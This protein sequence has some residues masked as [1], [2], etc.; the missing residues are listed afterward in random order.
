MNKRRA[1]LIPTF[2]PHF[3]KCIKFLDSC[4]VFEIG[5]CVPKFFVTSNK[6]EETE[7][8]LLVKDYNSVTVLNI[9]DVLARLN[10]SKVTISTFNI[11]SGISKFSYQSV[12]KIYGGFFLCKLTNVD[13]ILI[14]DSESILFKPTDFNDLF[15]D[16]FS[17]PKVYCSK[18]SDPILQQVNDESASLLGNQALSSFIRER[19]NFEAQTWFLEKDILID[20]FNYCEKVNQEPLI[21]SVARKTYV[22]EIIAYQWFIYL[23]P[24]KYGNYKFIKIEDL[25]FTY[26]NT[27]QA[28]LFLKAFAGARFGII[29]QFLY[30]VNKDNLPGIIQMIN[31]EKLHFVRIEK[32]FQCFSQKDIETGTLVLKQDCLKVIVCSEDGVQILNKIFNKGR[33]IG[34]LKSVVS[35]AKRYLRKR[36]NKFIF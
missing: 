32:H 23:H 29:E 3:P 16:Y 4:D 20:F 14:L 24:E 25:I 1:L 7:L 15:S 10:L 31:T 6:T 35:S 17:S 12:K 18:I 9:E 19:W 28:L 34:I 5:D 11:E 22:F 33:I 2:K 36:N 26:L 30:G 27:D 8:T 21:L 13:Q